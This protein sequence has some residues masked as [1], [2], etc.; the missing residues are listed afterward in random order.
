VSP[1]QSAALS[2]ST[3]PAFVFDPGQEGT[4]WLVFTSAF[5]E[6]RPFAWGRVRVPAT[7]PG[8]V[9]F[10]VP[11]RAWRAVAA[12]ARRSAGGSVPA[13]GT[14]TVV[15]RDALGRLVPAAAPRAITVN[16]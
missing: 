13:P 14:W 7:A 12:A 3:P 8:P 10:T 4:A 9:N 5:E 1:A 2:A 11:E 15:V 16:P 6:D